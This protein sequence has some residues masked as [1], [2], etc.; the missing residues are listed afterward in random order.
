MINCSTFHPQGSWRRS[1]GARTRTTA[2][3]WPSVRQKISSRLGQLWIFKVKLHFFSVAKYKDG[4][5]GYGGEIPCCQYWKGNWTKR[6]ELQQKSDISVQATFF[7]LWMRTSLLPSTTA[8]LPGR[9]LTI[10]L[11]PT[12]RSLPA[13]CLPTIF[14]NFSN[15]SR[16]TGQRL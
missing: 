3:R 5:G 12:P 11:P 9:R 16:R 10:C 2:T 8:S 4:Q 14:S 1:S 6:G 15:T 13:K 7:R